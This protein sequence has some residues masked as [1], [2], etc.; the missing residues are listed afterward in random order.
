MSYTTISEDAYNKIFNNYLEDIKTKAI[1]D[2]RTKS[3]FWTKKYENPRFKT[4]DYVELKSQECDLYEIINIMKNKSTFELYL[5][6]NPSSDNIF[7]YHY[8]GF[9]Y[10]DFIV[11]NLNFCN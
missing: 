9:L 10:N 3:S 8:R 7:D 1:D 5:D 4:H 6:S 11:N 2:I